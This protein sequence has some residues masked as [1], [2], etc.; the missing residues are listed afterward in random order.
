MTEPSTR[1]LSLSLRSKL[2]LLALVPA[3]TGYV[4]RHQ[5]QLLSASLFMIAAGLFL[6]AAA[7]PLL[8]SKLDRPD[9]AVDR[10]M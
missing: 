5:E 2:S 7:A 1:G 10:E 3:L 6:A 4:L 8:R 9:P